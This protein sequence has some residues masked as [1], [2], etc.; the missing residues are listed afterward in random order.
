MRDIRVPLDEEI[1][2]EIKTGPLSITGG[3][4]AASWVRQLILK[5]LER[6]RSIKNGNSQLNV[7]AFHN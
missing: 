5:E 3:Q 2:E 6:Y 1:I 4:G 7:E